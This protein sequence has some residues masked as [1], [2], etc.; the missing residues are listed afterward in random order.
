MKS[1][2]RTHVGQCKEVVIYAPIYRN[3]GQLR[4]RLNEFDELVN[5]R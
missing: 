3:D 1:L 4:A 2:A 5:C